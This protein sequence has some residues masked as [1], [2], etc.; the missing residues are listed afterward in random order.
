MTTRTIEE[1]LVASLQDAHAIEQQA[2]AQLKRAP[3]I[4]GDE[5]LALAL[6]QHEPETERHE[7]L[8]RE[9]LEAHGASPSAVRDMAGSVGGAGFVGFAGAQ[10]DTPG[11][12][13]T[14]AFSY[15]HLELAMYE[16]LARLADLAGDHETAVI[17]HRIRGEEAAMAERIAGTFDRTALASLQAGGESDPAER[18]TP[19][20]EDAHAIE[21]QART[22]LEKAIELGGDPQLERA[23]REHLEQTRG[24]VATIEALL[25]QRGESPS[26]LKDAALK[27][28]ALNWGAFFAAQAET[29]GKLAAF[30]YAF[31]HLEIGAYEHLRR[32]ARAA[33]DEQ[34]ASAAEQILTEERA[35]AQSVLEGFDAAVRASLEA[36]G[37]ID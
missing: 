13:A 25:E 32:I 33:G 10:S 34:V 21:V 29:P 23:Y 19:Y 1:Q 20:L 35:A 17:A 7:Q 30:A 16:L 36:V 28:G 18:L 4:A 24:H 27:T 2:L 26:K 31:E 6:R 12:L 22:L 3:Q 15:E 8:V 5:A 9:R 37:A 11:K 14:H